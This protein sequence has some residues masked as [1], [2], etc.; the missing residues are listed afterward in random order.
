MGWALVVWTDG[1]GTRLGGADFV[2]GAGVLGAMLVM[3]ADGVLVLVGTREGTCVGG[4][5]ALGGGAAT[6]EVVVRML[7][8][9]APMGSMGSRAATKTAD[10]MMP[11]AARP[12]ALTPIAADAME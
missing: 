3:I 2:G 9:T 10:T 6:V 8:T 12:S 11:T 1:G 7:G 5:G 4:A